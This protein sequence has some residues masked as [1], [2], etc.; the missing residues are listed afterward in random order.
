MPPPSENRTWQI[1]FLL[2]DDKIISRLIH[3]TIWFLTRD[4]RLRNLAGRA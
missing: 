3:A 2:F 1:H 4:A